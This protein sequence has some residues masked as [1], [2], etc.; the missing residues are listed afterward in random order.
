MTSTAVLPSN[1]SLG[2]TINLVPRDF[3]IFLGKSPG[4]EGHLYYPILS[5][6]KAP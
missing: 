1:D 5:E 2:R 6:V 3:P 4:D